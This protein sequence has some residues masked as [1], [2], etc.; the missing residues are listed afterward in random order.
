MPNPR[1]T[2]LYAHS[3]ETA[4]RSG[5]EPL[6]EHLAAVATRAAGFAESFGWDVVA[7]AIGLLHDIGK[8][9]EGYQAYIATPREPGRTVKGPDHSTAGARIAVE[10]YGPMV[11]KM[12]AFAI[13]GHHAGLADA[14]ELQQRLG[15]ERRIEPY[16]GWEA[17]AGPLP[18]LTELKPRRPLQRG[19]HAGFSQ[20]FLTR[21][22]FSCLVDADFLETE[23]FYAASKGEE[24]EREGFTALPEL[25]DRLRAY[26]AG[27]LRSEGTDSVQALRGRVLRH[28]VERAELAPGLFTLTVPTGGGKTL[29]SLSFALEHAL[30][31]GMRRVVHVIPFTS[32]IEQTAAV[33]REA[34]GTKDDVLE[35]HAS[36][37]WETA[38]NLAEDDEGRDG[39]AKLQK[40]AENWAAPIV[41]TTAVQFF[42][43]LFA[44]RTSRCRKLH[45]LAKAVIVLDEAQTLPLPLLRPCMAALE[46]L[47]LN[48]G[49]SIV[50]CTAT[51]PALREKDGFP[52]GFPIGEEREL[53]PEPKA[54]FAELKRVEVERLPVP[55]SDEVIAA[56]FAEQPQMLCIVNSRA[57]ARELF[58]AI[59]HLP[60]A[61]HLSTLMCPRH[62]RQ[63]LEQARQRLKAGEPVRV[64]STSLIEAGVDASFPEVW[65]ASAGLD[66]IIQAA[67]RC[68]RHGERE[69][70]RVVVF[71][72]EGK[73]PPHEIAQFWQAAQ[74][75][76]AAHEDPLTLEAIEAYFRELYFNKGAH[77]RPREDPLDAVKV[78]ERAGGTLAALK[79]RADRLD[80]P[81]RGIAEAFRLIDAVMATV[82]VPF[83]EEA[84]KLLKEMGA[85]E[86]PTSGHMRRLQQFTV[87]IPRQVRGE[88][89]VMGAL[90]PVHPAI[91]EELLTFVD[92]AHY[93]PQTGLDIW[94]PGER[95]I[96]S[97]IF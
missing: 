12:M 35:H 88:W 67:G 62:R 16:Q 11:G 85:M 68:N 70:G 65:R 7:R 39:L 43:S 79:E 92:R 58:E 1:T 5:W 95:S 81:F 49:A 80:F 64:V 69:R 34:L 90:R 83:D 10:A 76:L 71:E 2:P 91:G 28:A 57:H 47:A 24:V 20:A 13:A 50:L 4:D 44:N 66:S 29:T 63:V 26:M 53:A 40:A 19:R 78:G 15:P 96:Q 82:V 36:F 93:R 60:G 42:E 72:A 74:P 14:V 9:S 56:R 17:Q 48:Y 77:D 37:D 23:R 97:G 84:Q 38:R 3:L 94:R 73:K 25:R 6:P 8:V 54:L 27:G 61:T 59:R 22:L 21:M 41:V 52:G 45:N 89:L 75:V 55:V 30:R 18:P 33:F 51:Q 86:R 32:V 46:E 31:H 87:S